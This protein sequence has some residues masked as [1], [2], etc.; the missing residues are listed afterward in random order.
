MPLAQ[1]SPQSQLETP[2]RDLPP[3]PND[4][5]DF[6]GKDAPSVRFSSFYF[7]LLLNLPCQEINK[8]TDCGPSHFHA[9][10]DGPRAST[11][12]DLGNSS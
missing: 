9:V 10:C 11:H 7:A 8:C 3:L 1:D 12:M 2:P 4:P 5:L 6:T